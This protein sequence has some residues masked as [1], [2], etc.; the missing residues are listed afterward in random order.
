MFAPPR[1]SSIISRLHADANSQTTEP[2]PDDFDP[3]H[4]AAIAIIVIL[5]SALGVI[6][7]LANF[8]N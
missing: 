8:A 4:G 5:T 7:T 3:D 1:Y 6:V 2:D